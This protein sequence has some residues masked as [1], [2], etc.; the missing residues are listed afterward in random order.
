MALTRDLVN[1]PGGSLVP[2]AFV[3]KARAALRGSARLKASVWDE[4]R[5]AKEKLGGLLCGLRFLFEEADGFGRHK[6]QIKAFVTERNDHLAGWEG[7]WRSA[8]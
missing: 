3:R 6:E 2:T 1:E 5:I 8:G 7:T 4:T